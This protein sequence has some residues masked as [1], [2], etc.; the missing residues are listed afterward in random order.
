MTVLEQLTKPKPLED[1]LK[2]SGN[3]IKVG[4]DIDG[5]VANLNDKL[6]ELANEMYYYPPHYYPR[7]L[8][9]ELKASDIITFDYTKCTP[10]NDEDMKQIF[11]VLETEKA[12]LEL[13]PLQDAQKVINYLHH[14]FEVYFITSRAKYYTNAK[15]QTFEWF[16]KHNIIYNQNN[17]FFDNKKV[18]L[19]KKLGISKFIEDRAETALELAENNINVLLLNYP[20]NNDPRQ[21]LIQK[22]NKHPKIERIYNTPKSYWLNLEKKMIN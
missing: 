19:S 17:F 18:E 6:L 21:E 20:W 3:I 4:I 10:L 16:D 13:K 14:F 1:L 9:K 8:K 2:T 11:K 22:I 7:K 12:L 5:V 15:E